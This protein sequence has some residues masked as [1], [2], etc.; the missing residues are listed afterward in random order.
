MV[1]VGG[2]DPLPL[3]LVVCVVIVVL[4]VII[5]LVWKMRRRGLKKKPYRNVIGA[6]FMTLSQDG[7]DDEVMT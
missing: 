3:V 2:S 6:G 5:I 7:S 4:L 1:L